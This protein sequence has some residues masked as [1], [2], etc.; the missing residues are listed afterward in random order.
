ML[1]SEVFCRSSLEIKMPLIVFCHFDDV[2]LYEKPLIIIVIVFFVFFCYDKNCCLDYCSHFKH[3]KEKLCV[4]NVNKP[5]GYMNFE[6]SIC[7]KY[8]H[9]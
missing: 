1:R 8:S 4:K 2:I 5:V 9:F 3:V 7:G 6:K